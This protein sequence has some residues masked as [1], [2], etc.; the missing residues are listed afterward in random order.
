MTCDMGHS[1]ALVG[2][3][4]EVAGRWPGDGRENALRVVAGVGCNEAATA[5]PFEMAVHLH[6]KR[7]WSDA[8]SHVERYVIKHA[9]SHAIEMAVQ[10]RSAM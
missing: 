3:G 6:A 9:I 5:M 1:G 7:I 2:Y 10:L 8:D 4:R